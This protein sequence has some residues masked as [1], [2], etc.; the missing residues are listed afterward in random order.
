MRGWSL[1]RVWLVVFVAV[2]VGGA[3]GNAVALW[4]QRATGTID[5]TTGGWGIPLSVAFAGNNGP[6]KFDGSLT[7]VPLVAQTSSVSYTISFAAV[8]NV[9]VTNPTSAVTV[10]VPPGASGRTPLAF[11]KKNNSVP[12]ELVVTITPSS[13]GVAGEPSKWRL[14]VVDKQTTITEIPGS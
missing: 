8:S 13:G 6:V 9:V 12:A 1:A 14:V 5:V 11:E 2:L 7:W 10:T 4:S 3:G